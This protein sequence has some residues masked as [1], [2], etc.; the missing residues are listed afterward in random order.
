VGF[1]R[2]G[3]GGHLAAHKRKESL[4][5]GYKADVLFPERLGVDVAVPYMF[6]GLKVV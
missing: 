2:S 4:L 3:V 1:F 5:P 6:R